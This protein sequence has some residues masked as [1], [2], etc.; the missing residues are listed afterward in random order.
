MIPSSK[1]TNVALLA[2]LALFAAALATPAPAAT[3]SAW[4]DRHS[5]YRHGEHWRGGLG[6]EG[7]GCYRY[8]YGPFYRRYGDNSNNWCYEGE[9]MYETSSLVISIR[10]VRVR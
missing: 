8:G 1:R 7:A 10:D 9:S 2:A 4:R 6:C 3:S 5:G